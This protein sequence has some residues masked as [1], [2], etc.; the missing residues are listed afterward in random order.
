MVRQCLHPLFL[1]DLRPVRS[2]FFERT[3]QLADKT[4]VVRSAYQS[5]SIICFI[6]LERLEIAGERDFISEVR[7]Y[8]EIKKITMGKFLKA[9]TAKLKATMTQKSPTKPVSFLLQIDMRDHE[10]HFQ[11]E[12]LFMDYASGLGRHTLKWLLRNNTAIVLQNVLVEISSP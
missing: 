4:L 9:W 11:I 1:P 10:K 3:K 12:G 2:L 6:D 7:S 5:V 8:E